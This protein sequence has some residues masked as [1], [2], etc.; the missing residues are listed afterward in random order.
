MPQLPVE[1][2]IRRPSG[3]AMTVPGPL[4]TRYTPCRA[5]KSAA[6]CS[7]P[8][9][10]PPPAR[11]NSPSWG[12]STVVR[13]RRRDNASICPERA[14]MP[15]ASST[16]GRSRSSSRRTRASHPG[17]RPRPQ[18]TSTASQ[19]P[20]R[21]RMGSS[22]SGDS[23]PS[24]DGRGNGMTSS[25]LAAATG[26]TGSGTPRYTRPDPVRTAARP[27][28]TAAP[29]KPT[30]PQMHSTLPKVPLWPMGSRRGRR[31][32]THEAVI[33][34]M[35]SPPGFSLSIARFCGDGEVFFPVRPEYLVPPSLT[36][37]R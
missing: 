3:A 10:K 5:A 35:P 28:N 25:H 30:L 31:P 29:E 15:S 6:A 7:L 21:R 23:L 24:R 4:S 36:A 26:H 11:R 37:P 12:V 13:P 33:S 9:D 14:F 19:A 34:S 2:T 18:P 1:F 20:A 17:P 32:R 8:R 16:R 22:A 27:A